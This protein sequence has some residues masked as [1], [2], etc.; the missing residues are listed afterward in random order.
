M[1]MDDPM[2]FR[3]QWNTIKTK[4][5]FSTFV[6]WETPSSKKSAPYRKIQS[7]RNA[8]QMTGIHMTQAPT[9]KNFRTEHRNRYTACKKN[10]LNHST[11]T[12]E[13]H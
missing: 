2:M 11:K 13:T 7:I 8:N 12:L 5:Y 6:S 9:E 4:Q 1:D 3:Q 10:Q